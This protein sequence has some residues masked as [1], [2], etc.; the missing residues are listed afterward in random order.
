MTLTQITR[1]ETLTRSAYLRIHIRGAGI[2]YNLMWNCALAD[3]V[4]SKSPP[5]PSGYL[6]DTWSWPVRALYTRRAFDTVQTN[7]SAGEI[8]RTRE[9][10]YL[11][12]LMLAVVS[13]TSSGAES[14]TTQAI[15]GPSIST[16]TTYTAGDAMTVTYAG[17]PGNQHD[18]VAI[19]PAGSP[20]STVGEW[21]FINGNVSGTQA[22]SG[23]AAGDYEARA[24]LDDSYNVLARFAFTVAP[25]TTNGTATITTDATSYTVGQTVTA[26]Y[27]NLPGNTY[28]WVAVSVAGSPATS[29]V[30]WHYTNGA[31]NGAQAFSGLAAGSYEARAY[32]NDS[33]TIVATSAFSVGTGG[34][35]GAAITTDAGTYT[36]GQTVTV[37]FSGLPGNTYDWVAIAPAG[38]P[39]S[40]V[41]RWE[42]TN[43]QQ[44]GTYVV[45]GLAD[46][47][48]EARAYLNDSYTRLATS[49][50]FV[51]GSPT[52]AASASS[53][54][55]GSDVTINWAG[56][57]GNTYDWVAVAPM[58]SADTGYVAWV[59]TGGAKMGS[60]VFSGLA[61]GQ[62][63]A[64]AYSNDSY[65]RVATSAT[66][67]V[68]VA[69]GPSVSTA[70]T[71]APNAPISVSFSNFPGNQADW[72]GL[73]DA[74]SP[75][76]A[77]LTWHYT[78]GAVSGTMMFSGLAAGSYEVRGFS[79]DS[80]TKIASTAFSVQ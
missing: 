23:V 6:N 29:Y 36:S 70:A 67:T 35:G 80:Y 25:V 40:A 37:S 4:V 49:T 60:H 48:Y 63:E 21:H 52:V 44:S 62:Y 53:Y 9:L 68:G 24:Y 73:F 32:V 12:A 27:T 38:S 17:M 58:G 22:F 18:W 16:G 26:T 55:T 51:V 59:Y 7:K 31:V 19:S 33:Y 45:T 28:D 56:L 72:I 46:G 39:D 64:R 69:T 41:V 13:C 1:D 14:D 74:A 79:N 66:F 10:G 15:A 30:A 3:T 76:T 65:T 75:D 61:D 78:A 47:D 71:Y 8:M 42:Y 77:P 54:A 43:G 5:N 2:T 57:P 50:D 20:D 34:G 11:A